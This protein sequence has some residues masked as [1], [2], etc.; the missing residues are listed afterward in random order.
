[1]TS[2]SPPP[3]LAARLARFPF[4]L[5]VVVVVFSLVVEEY[6]PFSRFPMYS[7]PDDETWYVYVA[8]AQG[9]PVAMLRHFG[10]SNTFVRKV[11][12]SN[13]E[14]L[15]EADAT[16][17][18][19]TAEANAATDTLEYLLRQRRPRKKKV[20]EF[21]ALQLIK[22][23]VEIAGDHVE[24][25]SDPLASIPV[26]PAASSPAGAPDATREDAR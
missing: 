7:K 15:R 18:R 23:N 25:S 8:D 11:F 12:K 14:R 21:G 2:T 4:K 6:F 20:R 24:R 19:E 26:P 16:L 22:V 1:M 13:R 10:V 9:Q 17:D 5:L 3:T